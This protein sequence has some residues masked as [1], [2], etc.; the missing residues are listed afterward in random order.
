M[1]RR[2]PPLDPRTLTPTA[3]SNPDDSTCP[4][5][6]SQKPYTL[7]WSVISPPNAR[8][9]LDSSTVAEGKAVT[10]TAQQNASFTVQLVAT[11]SK[12]AVST[13]VTKDIVVSCPVPFTVGAPDISAV[14]PPSASDTFSRG[15]A[16]AFTF[17]SGDR[18]TVA[19]TAA[20]SAACRSTNDTFSYRWTLLDRPASSNATLNSATLAQPTFVA[21]V[22]GGTYKLQVEVTDSIGNGK[23]SAVGTFTA[24]TCGKNPIVASATDITTGSPQPFDPRTLKVA[25]SGTTFSDDD[26]ATKCPTRFAQTYTFAWST[27]GGTFSAPSAAQTGFAPGASAN[28]S[29]QILVKGSNG[30]STTATI[31]VNAVCAAPFM[32]SPN[33]GVAFSGSPDVGSAPPRSLVGGSFNVYR[34][35]VVTVSTAAG[36]SCF[37]PANAGLTYDW[38]LTAANGSV[39]H[40]TTASAS[41]TIDQPDGSY[42]ASVVVKDALG[43]ASTAKTASFKAAGCGASPIFASINDIPGAKP[44]DD[45]AF[46]AGFAPGRTTFSDDDVGSICPTH[47]ASQYTFKWSVASSTPDVGFIFDTTHAASVAFSPGGNAVYNIRLAISGGPRQ[48]EFFKLVTVS[49]SD[50]IPKAGAISVS[51]S[52]LGYNT[53]AFAGRFFRDDTVTLSTAAPTSLCFSSTQAA[54]YLWSLRRPLGSTD[55]AF[56]TTSPNPSFVADVSAGLWEVTLI[57]VDKLGNRSN[58]RTQPFTAESCGINPV[59]AKVVDTGV[60][61]GKEFDPHLLTAVPNVGAFFSPD[62]NPASCPQRFARTYTYAWSLTPASGAIGSNY[63][64]SP[65]SPSASQATLQA[66][67]NGD[68]AVSVAVLGHNASSPDQSDSPLTHVNVNCSL[69]APQFGTP[70]ISI[71]LVTPPAGDTFTHSPGQFFRDDAVKVQAPATFQCFSPGNAVATYNWSMTIDDATAVTGGPAAPAYDNAAS[72]TPTFIANWPARRFVSGVRV[73]DQFQNYGPVQTP[74]PPVFTTQTFTADACGAKPINTGM[75]INQAFFNSAETLAQDPRTLTV[76]PP[77]GFFSDDKNPAICPS[78]FGAAT[79]YAFAWSLQPSG[80][81]TSFIPANAQTTKFTPAA[82]SNYLVRATVSANGRSGFVEDSVDATCSPTDARPSHQF[83]TGVP[84]VVQA[85]GVTVRPG[86]YFVGDTLRLGSTVSRACLTNTT[87]SFAWSL[88]R[89]PGVPAVE[90]FDP[91]STIP[92][93]PTSAAQHP[94]FVPTLYTNDYL[95]KLTITDTNGNASNL[96]S[97]TVHTST[98]GRDPPIVTFVSASQSFAAILQQLPTETSP[99]VDTLL[100]QQ[101]PTEPPFVAPT[102]GGNSTHFPVPFY[103]DERSAGA[104]NARA[105]PIAVDLRITDSLG[106]SSPDACPAFTYSTL[107]LGVPAGS[108]T[109]ASVA[110]VTPTPS[111]TTTVANGGGITLTFSA[112]VGDSRVPPCVAGVCTLLSAEYEPLLGLKFGNR[113][114]AVDV[115]GVR[116]RLAGRDNGTNS[117]S[118]CGRNAPTASFTPPDRTGITTN[119]PVTLIAADDVDNEKL[120]LSGVPTPSSAGCGLGQTITYQWSATSVPATATFDFAVAGIVTNLP[121]ASTA[122][123]NVT[124]TGKQEADYLVS[125][126]RVTDSTARSAGPVINTY[127]AFLPLVLTPDSINVTANATGH[128]ASVPARAGFTY[129][130]SI[131]NGTLTNTGGTA[132]ELV[133]GRNRITYTAGASGTI[134]ISVVERNT[135]GVAS[136]AATA[137]INIVAAPTIATFSAASTTPAC[138]GGTTLTGT[139]SPTG[140]TGVITEGTTSVAPTLASGFSVATGPLTPGAHTFDLEVTNPAGT[141]TKTTTTSTPPSVTINCI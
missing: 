55:V 98:C 29:V 102:R 56:N 72:A 1:S 73:R 131:T 21:D 40:V 34:D 22:A 52:T 122:R 69:P 19:A 66:G 80:A 6:Y 107:S 126:D 77:G 95:A 85:D 54:S 105:N 45:H 103:L 18:V 118:H 116:I 101:S 20:S 128:T 27:S 94:T 70:A 88:E 64:F 32:S 11:G 133:A 33:L 92:A 10:F 90:P 106:T 14:T 120:L 63:T 57:V 135:A 36:S 49:C 3:V 83:L 41:F 51:G 81:S 12:G 16:G 61:A 67:H 115:G 129:Q 99:V 58:P 93:G 13:P 5:K 136:P 124:F 139:F 119:V 140:S 2:S 117:V 74:L 28:Y 111:A 76:N 123:D 132:G 82:S 137:T 113:P 79:T 65:N 114:A 62:D 39:T 8:Y 42:A 87:F 30:Q 91:S 15:S 31:A 53:G 24:G 47:F 141:A 127:T 78:R 9:M 112:D 50:L 17:F 59:A 44:F 23:T 35:D 48:A 71:A 86:P 108:L 104:P 130:W 84:V 138:A 38:T 110:A 109:A 125:L 97:G 75:T 134:A 100:I 43:N 25:S 96:A 26:E 121:V 4:A 37:S 89:A 46:A 7:T 60:A 68:Y